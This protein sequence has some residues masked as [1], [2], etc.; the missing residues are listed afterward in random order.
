MFSGIL[1]IGILSIYYSQTNQHQDQT[2]M[3]KDASGLYLDQ[4]LLGRG[5]AE[6]VIFV[7]GSLFAIIMLLSDGAVGDIGHMLLVF[8]M[9][10]FSLFS[11]IWWIIGIVVLTRSSSS[12]VSEGN[13]AAI[14]AIVELALF[15]L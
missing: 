9:A 8:F 14:M 7:F 6:I 3:Q 1:V 12:C 10:L 4:W 13:A 5:I 15:I 11:F 2:C